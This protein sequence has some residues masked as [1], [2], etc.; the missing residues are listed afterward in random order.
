MNSTIITTNPDS[1]AAIRVVPAFSARAREM[2]A[3]FEDVFKNPLQAR[4]ERFCWDYWNVPGQYRLLRTPMQQFFGKAGQALNAELT[5][6]GRRYLG[7]QMIS[8]P[9]MSV[10]L[11]GHYQSLHSDVPHGPWS[12][13]FS[14]SP[15]S[16]AAWPKRP[17]R[18]GETLVAKPKLLRYFR[19]L[20]S[21]ESDEETQLFHRLPQP[22]NQLTLFDPRYPHGV[23]RVEGNDDLTRARVVIHGWFT[24]PRP[25]VDGALSTK[26]AQ[27]GMDLIAEHLMG[28]LEGYTGLLSL[29]LS[30][31]AA[32][33]L[34]RAEVLAAHL[35]NILGDVVPPKLLKQVFAPLAEQAHGLFPR[36]SGPTTLT[37]PI[38]FRA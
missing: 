3:H 2:R 16:R 30:V 31:N 8:H 13:V 6:Y 28:A 11:D 25:T 20:K 36:A 38:E 35:T 18:G 5:E 34:T 15:Y 32:G 22:F 14:L 26:K 17:F 7:C 23:S 33:K 24:E 9:W 4:T 37:L 21:D 12:F 27:Y 1:F 19:D 29:R 10:Y